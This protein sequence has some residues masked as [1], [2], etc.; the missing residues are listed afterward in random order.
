MDVRDRMREDILSGRLVPGQRLT[1]PAIADRYDASVGVTREALT[2]LVSQGLVK[3][4]AHQGHIVMPISSADLQ[5]L[6]AARLTIEPL[7]LRDSINNRSLDWEARLVAA[8]HVMA[9][10]YAAVAPRRTPSKKVQSDG[11][12]REAWAS[13]HSAFHD[14]LFSACGNG[15]LLAIT[16]NLGEE[17]ELYRRWSDSLGAPRDVMDEHRAL[18]DAAIAGDAESAAERLREHIKRTASGLIRAHAADGEPVSAPKS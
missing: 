11:E 17:A 13:A 7:V 3:V 8:H 6:T 5:E 10:S 15:R 4:R 12:L 16:R 1:F 2:W 14:A 18:M 9:A